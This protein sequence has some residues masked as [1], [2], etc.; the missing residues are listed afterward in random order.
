MSMYFEL[1]SLNMF[2]HYQY[3]ISSVIKKGYLMLQKYTIHMLK[4]L[5]KA[6]KIYLDQTHVSAKTLLLIPYVRLDLIN[7]AVDGALNYIQYV[8][9]L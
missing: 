7:E 9:R 1:T 2:V 5:L 3:V 6:M 8:K 4:Q